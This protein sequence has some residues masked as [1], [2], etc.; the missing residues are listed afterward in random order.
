MHVM[1]AII[2]VFVYFLD[3]ISMS[4]SFLDG[5]GV[6]VGGE[7]VGHYCVVIH[8]LTFLFAILAFSHIPSLFAFPHSYLHS[9]I[10]ILAPSSY[11][12][13]LFSSLTS[14][15]RRGG[16]LLP[17]AVTPPCDP[18]IARDCI[19]YIPDVG[20]PYPHSLYPLPL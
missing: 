14:S 6:G 3:S 10:L 4:L 2:G 9:R 8:I 13:V 18:L 7:G 20:V 16:V 12:C 19:V 17:M 15:W 5:Q 11:S 1:P